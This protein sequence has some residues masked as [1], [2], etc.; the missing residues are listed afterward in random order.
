[1]KQK[2]EWRIEQKKTKEDCLTAL[3]TTIRKDLAT[4]IRKHAHELI[5]Q[6]KTVRTAIKEGLSPDLKPFDYNIYDVFENKA[7]ATFHPNIGLLKTAIEE[8]WN[9]MSE[10]FI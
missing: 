10:E 5:V 2:W 9:K 1:M 7:N 3:A 8:E 6:E 4:S